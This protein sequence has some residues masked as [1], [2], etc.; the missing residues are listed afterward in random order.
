MCA[1]DE[2]M[3][4]G[5]VNQYSASDCF[6]GYS[7]DDDELCLAFGC[8][9]CLSLRIFSNKKELKKGRKTNAK[10]LLL[11]VV[12]VICETERGE[13]STQARYKS[14]AH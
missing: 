10:S 14:W 7:A 8:L 1:V 3:I 5:L 2:R 12:D 9:P 13:N 4:I 11:V 6:L